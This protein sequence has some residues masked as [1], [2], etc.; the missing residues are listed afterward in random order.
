MY[1]SQLATSELEA[2]YGSGT[3]D[4]DITFKSSSP[5]TCKLSPKPQFPKS[6]Q[7]TTLFPTDRKIYGSVCGGVGRGRAFQ[8]KCSMGTLMCVDV[9]FSAVISISHLLHGEAWSESLSYSR[10]KCRKR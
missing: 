8:T 9:V 4:Q 1:H 6:P 7:T 5:I 10:A 2:E 3:M